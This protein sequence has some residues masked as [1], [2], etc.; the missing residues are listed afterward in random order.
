MA[1][2]APIL[3]WISDQ[4]KQCTYVNR[5]WLDFTGRRMEQ[6][7]GTG[8]TAHVHP[9][10]HKRG[11]EIFTS[12]FDRREAFE[13][14]Y[15]LL[16]A[17]GQFRWVYDRGTPIFSPAGEFTG[18]IGSCIDITERKRHEETQ[19]RLL[20]EVDQMK[21]QLQA[22]N[23]YLQEEIKLERDFNEIIG[24]SDAIKRVLFNIEK[25]ARTD[26]P[27]LITGETG[28][29][30]ELVARAIHSAS[31]RNH[32]PLVKVNCAALPSTL[33]ESELFGHERGAFTGADSR[34][35]GRF[36]LSD[37]AT[38]FLD[39]I[40]DLPMES[41][42]KLLR[43]LQEGEFERLGSNKTFKTDVR[44]IAASNRDLNA[45]VE[46]GLF[47]KDL[48]YRLNVFPITVP[49][50]RERREDIPP[51]LAHFVARFSKRSGRAIDSIPAATMNSLEN[52][53]WPGN[54]RELANVIERAV[55]SSKESTLV[56]AE[57]LDAWETIQAPIQVKS[58]E[59]IERDYIL[60]VLEAT[61]GRIEGPRGAAR[62][63][64]LNPSTLRGRIAKLRITRASQT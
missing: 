27:V 6:E 15:R 18:Y 24:R 46:R 35:Q 59:E 39:E 43:V 53:T 4:D 62:I 28:T 42:V 38:I 11:L 63:L 21:N 3:I 36:E 52:Y 19:R 57:P 61:G 25:V 60:E 58:L 29:G 14:E 16:R 64:G 40:G 44:I 7:L 8:W 41:Q 55:I 32:R 10:D 23:I 33:I 54:V 20:Q 5:R 9:D 31:A 51:L 22:D 47:R 49:P 2:N 26:T 56:L 12:A 13:G 48:W 1:D 17:D 45:E 50:L 30:K 34:R 37:G